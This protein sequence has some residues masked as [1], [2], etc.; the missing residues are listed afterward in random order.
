VLAGARLRPEG[1]NADPRIVG[2]LGGG[3]T[4]YQ[5]TAGAPA[6]GRGAPVASPRGMG[7]RDYFDDATPQGGTYDT[8]A[9]ELSGT[10]SGTNSNAAPVG[11]TTVSPSV[12]VADIWTTDA[13]G[14]PRPVFANNTTVNYK[15]RVV[16]DQGQPVPGVTVTSRVYA[17]DWSWLTPTTL[18][19]VTDSAGVADFSVPSGGSD[20]IHTIV[21]VDVAP[22]A[23]LYYDSALDSESPGLPGPV[24]QVQ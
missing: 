14:T 1:T 12:R 18:S 9:D 15:V 5:L 8:G 21:P 10:L 7:A 20:G 23:S 17:Q 6:V 2:S 3:P 4:A 13:S 19:D 22:P 16:D 24:T 11:H